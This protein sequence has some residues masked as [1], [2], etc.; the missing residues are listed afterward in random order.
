V[1]YVTDLLRA[2]WRDDTCVVC[3]AQLLLA[4]EF[5]VTDRPGPDS[6]YD[7]DLGYRVNVHTGSPTCVHPYRVGLPVGAYAS[8]GVPV[9]AIPEEPPAPTPPALVLP[10]DVTDLEGW[11]V[12]VLRDAGPDRMHRALAAAESQA[13]ERFPAG[14]VVAAMR[15]VLSVELARRH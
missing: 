14:E 2:Q 3:P 9:P 13:V 11:L 10:V 5:D 15:K 6:R 7:P 4:G 8:G 12:A 1:E